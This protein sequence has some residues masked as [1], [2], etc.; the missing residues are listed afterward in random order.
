MTCRFLPLLIAIGGCTEASDFLP[1]VSFDR[2]EVRE[3]DWTDIQTDFVFRVDNPNPVR[4][5][6]ASDPKT[7]LM[8]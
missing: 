3:I 2:L 4:V 5:G 6:V 7:F 1:K 8:R